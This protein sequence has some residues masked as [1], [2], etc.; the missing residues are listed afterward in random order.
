M[1]YLTENDVKQTLTVAEAVD[2]AEKGIL[3]DARGQVAGDKFYMN[4]G[5]TGFLKPFAGYLAGEEYAYVK[6]FSYFP[7]N[8]TQYGLPTTASQVL[9]YDARTGFP[10]C[11]M[12]AGWV[13]GLK[14]GASTTITA[15]WLAREDA[16]T[17]AIFGAGMQGRMHLRALAQRFN[18]DRAWVLD[19][20]PEVAQRMATELGPDLSFPVEAVPLEAREQVVRQADVIVLVTTGNQPLVEYDWLKPG[21]FIAKMG[22][23]QEVDLDVVRRADKV[24]VDRWKYVSPRTPELLKLAQE[25]F[26]ESAIHGEWP[27]IVA[28]RIPGRESDRE[29]ILY[30]ALG[31]WGEYAAIL[32][33]VYRRAR[34]KGLGLRIGSSLNGD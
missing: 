33:E 18:F 13:T 23:F 25:G 17:V 31:I 12:E 28:G 22:S 10:V 2:L 11:L 19:L 21:A 16:S 27:D 15:R 30:I 29:I 24:I 7:E 6:I 26:D 3:A 4:V 8:P 32:P 14:T 1:L 9:L 34:Q 5:D 20:Y